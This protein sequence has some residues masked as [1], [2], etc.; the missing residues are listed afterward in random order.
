MTTMSLPELIAADDSGNESDYSASE[1]SDD[2]QS[3]KH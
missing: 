1:W 2:I 3:L